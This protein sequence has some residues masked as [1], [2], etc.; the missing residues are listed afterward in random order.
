MEHN[1]WYGADDFKNARKTIADYEEL[2][3][4][5]PRRF[6]SRRR[7]KQHV[8]PETPLFAHPRRRLT[9]R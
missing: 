9:T 8:L 5:L 7:P 3:Q 6:P 2:N 4:H 1:T